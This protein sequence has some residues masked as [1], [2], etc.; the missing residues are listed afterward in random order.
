MCQ[1]Q[2]VFYK[3]LFSLKRRSFFL[4]IITM[5]AIVIARESDDDVKQVKVGNFAV[6]GTTQPGTA[7]GF[8][9]NI[10]DKYSSLGIFYPLITLGKDQNFTQIISEVIYGIRDDLSILLSFPTAVKFKYDGYRSS[11]SL[12]IIV[13]ME[14]APYE[15]HMPTYSNQFSLVGSVILPTGNEC[16]IP[17]TGHGSPSFL[18]GFVAVHLSTEWYCLYLKWRTFDYQK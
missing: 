15:Q 1:K 13:Q 2:F 12:D 3:N 7:S 16:K 9:Q 11:G 4:T 18:L 8:G 5:C 10:I 17:A 14:Y 6:S